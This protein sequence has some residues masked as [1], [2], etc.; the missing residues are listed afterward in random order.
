MQRDVALISPLSKTGLVGEGFYFR[1]P[2]FGLLKLASLTPEPWK[3]L[4]I[5]EKVEELDLEIRPDLVGITSMTATATRAYQI[6]DHFRRRGVTVVM[7]GMH[8]SSVPEEALRYCD[9]VVVGEAE[10]LWPV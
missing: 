9:S 4:I 1:M 10:G 2:A 6:A 8:A 3:P 7:G 5:D